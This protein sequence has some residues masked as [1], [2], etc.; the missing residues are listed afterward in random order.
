MFFYKFYKIFVIHL[1]CTFTPK[2]VL[3]S[4]GDMDVA[5]LS[6]VICVYEQKTKHYLFCI[7]RIWL[8]KKWVKQSEASSR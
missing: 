7:A 8:N 2:M 1:F 3:L 6:E 4:R 5:M